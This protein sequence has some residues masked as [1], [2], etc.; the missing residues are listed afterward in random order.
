VTKWTVVEATDPACRCTWPESAWRHLPPHDGTLTD[1]GMH[2]PFEPMGEHQ[3]HFTCRCG[4]SITSLQ[5]SAGVPSDRSVDAGPASQPTPTL[6]DDA[7]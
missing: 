1:G 4:A 2:H 7:P 3:H 5:G 6:T